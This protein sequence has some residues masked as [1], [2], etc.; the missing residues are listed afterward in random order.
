MGAERAAAGELHEAAV[1]LRQDAEDTRE[2]IEAVLVQRGAIVMAVESVAA[3]RDA[4]ARTRPD[5]LVSDSGMR[6][7]DGYTLI[8]EVRAR[9]VDSLRAIAAALNARGVRTA[10]DGGWV[11]TQ[12][13]AV[14][15]R[16]KHT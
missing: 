9:G 14:L 12:V 6:G 4:L 8:R 15:A 2:L 1:T 5:V 3:A 13:A 11:A 10:R 7:E 16:A